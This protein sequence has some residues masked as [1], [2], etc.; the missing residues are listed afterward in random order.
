MATNIMRRL[1]KSKVKYIVVHC[2]ATMPGQ[3]C[4]AEVID[5]WHVAKGWHMIGYHYVVMPDGEVQPGR[6]LF[7]QGAHVGKP[8]NY[9]DVSI[10]VCY[11]GGLDEQG[12]SADT[13]TDAQKASLL[14]LLRHLKKKFPQARIVGHRDLNPGK[15]CPCF[16]ATAYNRETEL[17]I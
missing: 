6:P 2:S 1:D 15:E 14:A 8:K 11:V 7:Y 5:R 16:D 10:G 12:Q 9:N 4:D 13:R 3:K 17:L